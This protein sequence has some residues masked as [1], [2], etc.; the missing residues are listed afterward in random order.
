MAA[1]KATKHPTIKAPI[2]KS[3]ETIL[4]AISEIRRI[5]IALRPSV[6]DDVGLAAA[7][8]SLGS[9][10]EQ[11]TGMKTSVLAQNVGNVLDDREKTVFIELLKK[12]LQTSQNTPRP[13]Q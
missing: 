11:Q 7:I 10:F 9:D 4:T 8:K 1:A 3:M 12:R 13:N 6:L 5:S 2:E